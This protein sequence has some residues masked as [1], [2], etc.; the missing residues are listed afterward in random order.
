M[1]L[2][3][4]LRHLDETDRTFQSESVDWALT[5]LRDRALDDQISSIVTTGAKVLDLGCGRGDLLARLK[6]EHRIHESGIEIE[7]EA[8]S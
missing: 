8:V 2:V 1:S 5:K 7:G 3:H 4:S 6:S